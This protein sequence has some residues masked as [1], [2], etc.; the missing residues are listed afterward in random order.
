MRVSGH[1]RE[2]YR[3]LK[4]SITKAINERILVQLLGKS[5]GFCCYKNEDRKLSL[6][7]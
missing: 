2:N 6:Q 7:L 3:R 4:V 1:K 5:M